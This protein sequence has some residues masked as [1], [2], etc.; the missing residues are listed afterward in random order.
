MKKKL[1]KL[2]TTE[3]IET[4]ICYFNALIILITC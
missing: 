3:Q 2:K 1:P 4:K